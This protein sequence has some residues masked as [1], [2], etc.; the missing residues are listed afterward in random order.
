MR[1][2]LIVIEAGDGCGKQTQSK[3]LY[4]RLAGE[5]RFVQK[6]EYPD[7]QSE[8]S[9]LIK[10]YLRGDFG[11]D[12]AQINPYAASAFYA[13]DR[14]ASY[15]TR[16]Q[17]FYAAGGII[18]ADRYTTSNM[19]HQAVKIS[20]IA[21]RVRFLDWLAELEF[22]LFK[23]PEPDLVLFLDMPLEYSLRLLKE[24]AAKEDRKNRDIHENSKDYLVA[25]YE[26]YKWLAE[27]FGWQIVNCAAEDSLKS[28]EAIH[29][30][31]YGLV[32]A[33]L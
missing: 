8:S 28:I 24:R 5:N 16:W 7:Y 23:L 29:E 17:F 18:I 2:K 15:K 27:R 31:I 22:E 9:A 33:C 14:Y 26:N 12:P 32:K 4:E 11:S 19:V 25:C 30:E 21:E 6:V 13:V 20:A 1:G 3:M 10:M